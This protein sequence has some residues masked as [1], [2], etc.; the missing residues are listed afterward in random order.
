MTGADSPCHSSEFRIRPRGRKSDY[1]SAITPCSALRCR[2]PC[3]HEQ[4]VHL[5]IRV[6]SEAKSPCLKRRSAILSRRA[7][8]ILLGFLLL[9]G[10]AFT[11]N[12]FR[13]Y[14]KAPME[15][16]ETYQGQRII[17]TTLQQSEGDWTSRAEL[18]DSGRRIPVAGGSDNR[19]QS[20]EE[21]RQAA[22]SMAAGAIDRARISTGKP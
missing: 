1:F 22:L 20:E 5:Q 17:V 2:I 13:E 18:L 4:I 3:E 8:S 9:S 14:L 12:R 6:M 15:Y 16:E 7:L 19:Y 21:A 10:C 11:Q